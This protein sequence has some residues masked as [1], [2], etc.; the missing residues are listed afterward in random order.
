[1]KWNLENIA[2]WTEGKIL[3][4][5]AESFDFVGTDTRSNLSDKLFIA[6]QGENYD[7][8][9]FLDQA[10]QK[11]AKALLIHR[12]EP[13]FEHLKSKI[14]IIQVANTL[15]ALQDFSSHYRKSVKTKIIGI[16]GSNGKTTTKEFTAQIL[17]SF[18]KT[19]YNQGSFNNHWGVPLTLLQIE[20]DAEFAV[21][22]MG[23]NH[24][25]EIKKLVE[26]ADPD[27]V[28]CTMVGTAHLEYFGTQKKIAEAKQEIYLYSRPD[29]VR[30]FNQDQD[31]TFDMMYPAAKAFP[32][33]RMLSF[34]DRNN[35]ADVYLHIDELSPQHIKVRG[36]IAGVEGQATVPVFGKQNLVNLMAACTTAYACQMPPEKIWQALS[37]CRTTWGR[38][39]FIKTKSGAEILF[40]GYNANPDS[41]VALIGNIP[42]LQ[43]SGRKIGIFGQMKE[44]GIDS[45]EAHRKIGLATGKAG[46]SEIYF[47]GEDCKFFA[48]GVFE[49]QFIGSTF[50]QSEFSTDLGEKL[51][52]SLQ[53]NDIVVI[54]GSRG[55]ATERFVD[56][57]EPLNWTKK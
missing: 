46:F 15:Q 2:T 41:M 29:T 8:H 56:F 17:N 20:A 24:A 18:K 51:Q 44:L 34:S 49:S 47:I 6:L 13:K 25:G 39:Q 33:S 52:C 3:S 48:E 38:N 42:L 16:T 7:A 26:I 28:V 57:C 37:E 43:T 4:Q 12:L 27:V 53:A 32:A 45:A 54:K 55:A 30:I 19:H 35:K 9:D 50:I 10:F 40:D 1:M 22:E 23:M 31:L 14:S 11:G 36:V 21:I 5:H